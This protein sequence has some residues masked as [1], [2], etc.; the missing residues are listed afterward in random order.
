MKK[1]K[2]LA[3]LAKIFCFIYMF[4]YLKEIERVYLHVLK[5]EKQYMKD[6]MMNLDKKLSD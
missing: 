3:I 6:V 2:I 5:K 4:L 1:Q